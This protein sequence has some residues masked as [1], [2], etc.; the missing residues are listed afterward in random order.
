[1]KKLMMVISIALIILLINSCNGNPFMVNLFSGIDNYDL[2]DSFE[3]AED[4]LNVP[5]DDLLEALSDDDVDQGFIDDV[6]ALL[7]GELDT[8]PAAATA[9]DQEAALLLADVHLAT[10]DA[11]DTINNVND[12]LVDAISDPET[13]DFD[14]PEGIMTD[15]FALDETL[16][17]EQ[18]E[19]IVE[20]QL[21]AF[22][23]AADAL[24]YYG[25]T[26]LAGQ[27]PSPEANA[28]ETAATAMIAG[29]TSYLIGNAVV[30][31]TANP[32]VPMTE[33]QA[34]AAIAASIVTGSDMPDM[35]SD[36][37]VD[38]AETTEDMFNAMLGNGLTEV[39]SDGFDL[40][41]FE[42]MGA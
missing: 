30:D 19:S 32:V 15:L 14:S 42:D 29:M 27:D 20:A 40:S 25:D 4:I 26:M 3:S 21:M 9:D 34:I 12:L 35:A 31:S 17:D 8:P 18:N 13:L 33:E 5:A 23:G 11:D 28:G 37:D 16:T 24:E 36:P 38:N 2:P 1:M 6:V 7:E 41:A 10:T 22:L 39:V